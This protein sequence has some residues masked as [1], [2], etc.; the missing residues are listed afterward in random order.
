MNTNEN[1]GVY[2]CKLRQVIAEVFYSQTLAAQQ[3]EVDCKKMRNSCLDD[4]TALAYHPWTG[5]HSQT[6]H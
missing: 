2:L 5:Y 1:I 4:R 3:E 6:S